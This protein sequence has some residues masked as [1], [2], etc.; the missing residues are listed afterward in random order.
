MEKSHSSYSGYLSP[1]K[2]P[3]C[4]N[5]YS[6]F[7]DTVCVYVWYATPKQP[8]N[9]KGMSKDPP[10]NER[11]DKNKSQSLNAIPSFT[12]PLYLELTQPNQETNETKE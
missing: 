5:T 3:F 10:K 12:N 11:A 2:V 6:I 7:S 9:T 4:N 8:S 1:T